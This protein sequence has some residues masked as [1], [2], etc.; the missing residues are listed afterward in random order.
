MGYNCYNIQNKDPQR[1]V[2]SPWTEPDIGMCNCV[3]KKSIGTPGNWRNIIEP[4][5]NRFSIFLGTLLSCLYAL[6]GYTVIPGIPH[7]KKQL[8]YPHGNPVSWNPRYPG[9]KGTG[10][11]TST[12][13]FRHD[14]TLVS[15]R[16][17]FWKNRKQQI[18]QQIIR[19]RVNT[20]GIHPRLRMAF[21]DIEP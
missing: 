14:E 13:T 11:L 3:E 1:Q 17:S 12:M 19:W 8:H 2:W 9:T 5:W 21:I 16:F 18:K 20:H 4:S 10:K 7:P 6:V 15:L